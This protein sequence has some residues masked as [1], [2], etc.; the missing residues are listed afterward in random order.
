MERYKFYKNILNEFDDFNSINKY[1]QYGGKTKAYWNAL[2]ELYP[3][4]LHLSVDNKPDYGEY[5][6]TYGEMTTASIKVIIE[7]Y[8]L[9]S[10]T[11]FIDMG[12]GTC[13]LPLFVA[14]F[15]HI[16]KSIGIE[17][18][19]E[20]VVYGKNLKQ[21][22][23]KDTH[24]PILDKVELIHEDMFKVNLTQKVEEEKTFVWISN[25]CFNDELSIKLF[26]KLH[27]ELPDDSI[28]GCSKIPSV[29]DESKFTLLATEIVEMSWNKTSTIILYKIN[30]KI[31]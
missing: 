5:P 11:V 24:K 14:G 2:T 6:L 10:Y 4:T 12:A 9:H 19:E 28:I 8:E 31:E 17:L 18:V 29:I 22:L 25:L 26:D 13:K 15:E 21:N 20:R 7:K 1:K 16:K 30:K 23:D 27:N 3:T